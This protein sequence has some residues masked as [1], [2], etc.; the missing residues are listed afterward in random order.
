MMRF[1][2]DTEEPHIPLITYKPEPGPADKMQV[3]GALSERT[4][5]GTP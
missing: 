4:Q 1:Q 3:A 2:E 5:Q